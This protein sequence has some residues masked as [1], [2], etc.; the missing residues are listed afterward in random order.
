MPNRPNL[1]FKSQLDWFITGEQTSL[2]HLIFNMRPIVSV[3][4]KKKKPI[5]SSAKCPIIP[6]AFTGATRWWKLLLL[7]NIYTCW[8]ENSPKPRSQWMM[9]MSFF[10]PANL[11][12]PPGTTMHDLNVSQP[13]RNDRFNTALTSTASFLF[14]KPFKHT[15]VLLCAHDDKKSCSD[16][17][18]FTRRLK[19]V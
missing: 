8:K 5:V 13:T 19:K 11:L 7:T 18:T 15:C 2:T 9:R 4:C 12:T 14:L 17:L 16:A 3:H 1:L 10:P 6:Q